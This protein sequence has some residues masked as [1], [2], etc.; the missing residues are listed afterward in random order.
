[1]DIKLFISE[2]RSDSIRPTEAL[3]EQFTNSE[4]LTS[5]KS[6]LASSQK[7]EAGLNAKLTEDAEEI[8]S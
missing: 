4:D 5:Y 2:N 1:M 7:M 6:A 8:K 3:A